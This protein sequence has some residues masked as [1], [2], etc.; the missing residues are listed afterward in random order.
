MLLLILLVCAT[1]FSGCT[2]KIFFPE[3]H[4]TV[5]SVTP[6]KLLLPKKTEPI[7]TEEG[8]VESEDDDVVLPG[9]AI[10]LLSDTNIPANLVSFSITYTTRLGDAI[11]SVAVPETPYSLQIPGEATTEI[12]MNPYTRRLFNLLELTSSDISP[13]NAKIVLNIKDI[14]GNRVQVAANCLCYARWDESEG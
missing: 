3:A 13:V 10:S 7:E 14:N 2:D 4:F 8:I 11:P 1:T 5:V 9:T 6:D 12:S